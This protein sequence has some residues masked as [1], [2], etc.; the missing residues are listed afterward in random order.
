[1]AQIPY[2]P[3]IEG[4]IPAFYG[5]LLNI[6]YTDN[7]AVGK[8]EYNGFNLRLKNA[9]DGSIIY[10]GYNQPVLQ[11]N[12]AQFD[13]SDAQGLTPGQYYKVQIAYVSGGEI[14]TYST[15]GVTKYSS[16]GISSIDGM[17]HSSMNAKTSRYIGRYT[18]SE[19]DVYE[20]EYSYE[21]NIYDYD[22]NLIATSEEHIHNSDLNYDDFYLS[23]ALDENQIYFIEYKVTTLNGLKV[24]SGYYKMIEQNLIDGDY[25]VKLSA[26]LNTENGY[27]TLLMST[28]NNMNGNVADVSVTGLYV[29]SRSSKTNGY[30][31]WNEITRFQ[32]K[33]ATLDNRIV[34]KD[35]TIQHG[36]TY[37][38]V[39]QQYNNYGV[40]SKK[41]ESNEIFADFY[42][43]FLFDGD[44]QL[45]IK[46]NPKVTTFKNVILEQKTDTIGGRYPTIYRN[47]N[48][49]YREMALSGLISFL[50]DVNCSLFL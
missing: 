13:I 35:F 22:Y 2:P 42:D 27:I 28:A 7:L 5:T 15:V 1:M 29:I 39:V 11:D 44:K 8:N 18:P 33:N 20:K 34:F 14:G 12:I 36:E 10:T 38:Y 19:E 25:D 21:F 17:S 31:D 47:G 24:S 50:S 26:Q 45:K 37:K 49:K 43:M 30:K 23:S 16:P 48:V 6:P 9:Y 41:M 4:V 46:F 3:Q 32:L 40:Y